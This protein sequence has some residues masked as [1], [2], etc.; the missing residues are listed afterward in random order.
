MSLLKGFVSA[1]VAHALFVLFFIP[2]LLAQDFDIPRATAR[3]E[4]EKADSDRAQSAY[5]TEES[6]YNQ[7]NEQ[8]SR[9]K[10]IEATAVS[11]LRYQQDTLSRIDRDIS[12]TDV[13]IRDAGFERDSEIRRRNDLNQDLPNLNNQIQRQQDRVRHYEDRLR[14]IEREIADERNRPRTGDY[15][16]CYV[17][18]GHEEHR[19]HCSSNPTQSV[20]DAAA[21]ADCN[22]THPTCVSRGCSQPASDDLA[23]LQRQRDEIQRDLAEV[24]SDLNHLVTNRDNCIRQI[25][26]ADD[27]IAVLE[28]SIRD[29]QSQLS[30]LARR[31]DSQIIAV[32]DARRTLASRSEDTRQAQR[33]LDDQR[34][35]LSSARS[36][37]ERQYA[38]AQSAYSYLQQVIANYNA[39]LNRIYGIADAAASQH[40]AREAAEVAPRPGEVAGS[41]SARSVGEAVG[42]SEGIARESAR[43]YKVGR[44]DAA[45]DQS[46]GIPYRS[47]KEVGFAEA[48][49]VARAADF[50]R[51]YNDALAAFLQVAPTESATIDISDSIPQD[52]GAAGQ[53]LSADTRQIVTKPAPAFNIPTEPSYRVPVYSEPNVSIPTADFRYRSEPCQNLALPEFEAKCRARYSSSYAAV[54]S[55]QYKS[56][57]LTSFRNVFD[58]EIGAIYD[59]ALSRGHPEEFSRSRDQGAKEQGVLDGFA[60]KISAARAEQYAAGKAALAAYAA[61]G[62]LLVIR[63]VTWSEQSG[64]DLFTPTDKVKVATIIDNFGGTASP[65]GRIKIKVS[66]INGFDSINFEERELPSLA[67]KT[68]TTI[69]GALT[70]IVGSGPAKSI[71]NL[72]GT[73]GQKSFDLKAEVHFPL[74]L[75]SLTLPRKPRVNEEL[76][77]ALTYKN[78]L[79]VESQL[80]Q[81]NFTNASNMVV[82]AGAP[83][84]VPALAPDAFQTVKV[85]LKPGV[86]VG[87][88]VPVLFQSKIEDSANE[89]GSVVQPFEQIINVERNASL[90][91]YDSAGRTVPSGSFDVIAGRSISFLVK[92]NFMSTR[93]LPGPFAVKSARRSNDTIKHSNNSTTGVNYGSWNPGTQAQPIRFSYDVPLALKGQR[94][95]VMI[96]LNEGAGAIHALMVYLNI[97]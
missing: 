59:Q 16:C 7:Y 10:S 32:D 65:K 73:V 29:H 85:K 63:E 24:E 3:Y 6:R 58:R 79:K 61:S 51:G 92:F 64:D 94:H 66:G 11:D 80:T 76:E 9:A 54:F 5:N 82:I 26:D 91:L 49:A 78:L 50:P 8:L 56:I 60:E 18:R 96:Q 17:D 40:S 15:T 84:E 44:Q 70:G 33:A 36:E 90:L 75:Q 25:R 45:S 77:A 68:R 46:L 14:R 74:E 43:G 55:S 20:A 71:L 41:A 87:D 39:E 1:I 37:W 86:W 30:A 72:A 34:S 57:F 69:N 23:R 38:E 95:Y 81:V 48:V 19:A 42:T 67:A 13:A 21:L 2:Q 22:V 27:R 83:F 12:Q 53:E 62:Y 52:P 47:G 93:P 4:Q 28:R 31:R 97:K 89:L 88:N 35:R